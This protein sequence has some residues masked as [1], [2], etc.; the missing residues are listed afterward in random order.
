MKG[1][2]FTV[3]AAGLLLAGL[4]SRHLYAMQ[5][6]AG[7]EYEKKALR[8]TVVVERTE[9]PRGRIF[10]RDGKLLVTNEPEFQLVA[11]PA[12]VVASRA[13]LGEVARL[14]QQPVG[15]FLGRLKK[16]RGLAPLETVVLARALDT[17]QV[18]RLTPVVGRLKGFSL[19]IQE[20]RRYTDPGHASHLLGYVGEITAEQLQGRRRKGFRMGDSL[21]QAGLEQTYDDLLRG[22]KGV[23]HLAIDALGRTVQSAEIRPPRPGYDLQLTLSWALQREAERALQATLDELFQRNGERS[24]GACVVMEA[25]TGRVLAMAGLPQ[26]DLRPFAR[27]IKQSEYSRLANDLAAPLLHRA[28][29]CSFSPGSTFKIINSSA[30]LQEG[31]CTSGTVFVC[32]GSYAGANCFVTSGHGAISFEGSLAHSCDVVYYMLGDRLGIGRLGRYCAA[33]GLGKPTGL[34][35]PGEVGGLL[36]SARWKKTVVGKDASDGGGGEWFQGDTV[37]MSIGQGYLLVTPLQMAVA[38]A[39]VA[40]GGSVV[41]PYLVEKA[42]SSGGRVG[43]RASG[44]PLRKVGVRPD[45]LA[46]VRQ[47]MRGAVLYGTGGAANSELITVAGKTGTVESFPSPFNPHGRNHTWFVSFA[48]YESP[49][50]VCVV[51]V[52]KSGGYGG[53]VSAPVARQAIDFYARHLRKK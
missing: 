48:P 26:Y 28:Y 4:L 15:K 52:E 17:A 31:L 34:D 23:R 40:N 42:V 27:G 6:L 38:T 12:E 21:G 10:D 2:L 20:R 41:K 18:V 39:A 51:C 35:V 16:A 49:K 22:R 11:V 14:A 9:A 3:G 8:N 30:S 37:N 53:G 13:V 33:F 7:P 44:K 1:R 50:I 25:R 43:Y 5:L 32:G 19:R 46:A 24:S 36:P 47:G 29:Q 45:L